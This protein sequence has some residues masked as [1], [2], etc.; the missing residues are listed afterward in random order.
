MF[1][2]ASEFRTCY[3]FDQFQLDRIHAATSLMQAE[4]R[5]CRVEVQD[6]D[7]HRVEYNQRRGGD[8]DDS[9]V[10]IDLSR[11]AV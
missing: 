7:F 2:R 5:L 3:G 9:C 1:T 10:R 6:D 11:S 4:T 8:A